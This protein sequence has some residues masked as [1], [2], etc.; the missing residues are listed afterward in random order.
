M[1]FRCLH[2]WC[3]VPSC[4]IPCDISS[5]FVTSW[6]LFCWLKCWILRCLKMH[7]THSPLYPRGWEIFGPHLKKAHIQPTLKLVVIRLDCF[8]KHIFTQ[9]NGGGNYSLQAAFVDIVHRFTNPTILLLEVFFVHFCFFVHLYKLQKSNFVYPDA[10]R[11]MPHRAVK[12]IDPR[13]LQITI[14]F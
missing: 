2:F 7:T 9:H 10:A 6:T 8:L 1:F 12:K 4:N 3:F 5:V 11:F 13:N 14:F